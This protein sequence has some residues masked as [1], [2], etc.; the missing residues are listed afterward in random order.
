MSLVEVYELIQESIN[1]Y[2]YKST[3]DD[4]QRYS[5]TGLKSIRR[6]IKNLE[7]ADLFKEVVRSLKSQSWF[8]GGANISIITS[9]E[10]TSIVKLLDSLVDGG[11]IVLDIIQKG[12][13]NLSNIINVII[14]SPFS[15][16]DLQNIS[17]EFKKAIEIPAAEVGGT[18]EVRSAQP[19]SVLL[20]VLLGTSAA[21]VIIGRIVKIATKANIEIKKAKIFNNY[22]ENIKINN[23][24]QQ[25]IVD[26]Q[27][28]MID[29]ILSEGAVDIEKGLDLDEDIQRV[30]RLKHAIETMSKL[31]SRG[32]KILPSPKESPEIKELFASQE[33][34]SNLLFEV[35]MK[36]LEAPNE[37]VA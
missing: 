6:I 21:V 29:K 34:D 28:I 18:V 8:K 13:R 2:V 7:E 23:E 33:E 31:M 36:E 25:G 12:N 32:V 24:M 26:A 11:N 4:Y 9:E 3:T 1:S 5:A 16:G 35:E 15:F 27:K 10:N 17:N 20:E 14:P 37:D 30:G 19:G 22:A